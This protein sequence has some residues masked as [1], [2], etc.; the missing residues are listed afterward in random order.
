MSDQ[1]IQ[2]QTQDQLFSDTNISMKSGRLVKDAE[3]IAE[4]KF[5]KFR[6]ASNK[7]YLDQNQEVKAVTNYFN[8]L[9]SSNLT[10]AFDAAQSLKKG[11][12]VYIK[13]EDNSKSFDTPEG[14]KQ[15]AITTFA[16]KVTKKQ[17]NPQAETSDQ[18]ASTQPS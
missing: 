2:N 1:P 15:T 9:V 11:E 6:I 18:S 12:W 14:Y 8:V 13:G 10:D 5:I 7:Q 17:E 4:G 16:Y 3:T